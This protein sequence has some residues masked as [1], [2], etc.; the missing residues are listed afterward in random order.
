MNAEPKL[1]PTV[2]ADERYRALAR[3]A[4]TVLWDAIGVVPG[5]VEPRWDVVKDYKDRD[6]LRL[7]LKDWTG[8]VRA[9]FSP[10]ELTHDYHLRWRFYK[11]WGDLLQ[12]R[13]RQQL[14]EFNEMVGVEGN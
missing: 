13:T 12:V 1:S 3:N 9:D 2:Q 10:D 7:T 4:T 11:L 5:P 8:E 14:R 6:L